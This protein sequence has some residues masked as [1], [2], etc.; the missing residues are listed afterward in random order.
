MVR[1]K[2]DFNKLENAEVGEQ[3]KVLISVIKMLDMEFDESVIDKENEFFI[4]S[5]KAL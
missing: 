1:Y 5:D 2:I 4:K 3:I